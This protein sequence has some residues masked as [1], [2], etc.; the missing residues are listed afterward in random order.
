MRSDRTGLTRRRMLAGTVA[1]GA[2]IALPTALL[3]AAPAAADE[4][5]AA[6][7][8]AGE[9]PKSPNGWPVAQ[10]ADK[11]STVWTRPV[12]GTGLSG[13]RVRIGEAEWLLT[14]LIRRFHYEIDELREGDVSGWL[15]PDRAGDGPE[16]N[17]AS[18]TAVVIRP[19]AYPPGVSGGFFDDQRAVIEDML[20]ELDGV[21]RWGGHDDRPFEALFYLDLPPGDERLARTAWKVRHWTVQPGKGAGSTAE[22]LAR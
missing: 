7:A 10:Q 15:A 8:G 21:V 4:R 12:T 11:V 2:A 20:D 13:V 19:R 6:S 5:R 1:A 9:V 17:R 3:A 22:R 18:G 14:H 16:A